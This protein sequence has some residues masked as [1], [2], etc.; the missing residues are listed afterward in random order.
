MA[1]PRPNHG[2]IMAKKGWGGYV[3][4]HSKATLG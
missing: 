2:Q 4:G 1:K 3:T